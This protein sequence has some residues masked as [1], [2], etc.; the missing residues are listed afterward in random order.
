MQA[1]ATAEKEAANAKKKGA[2]PD[3]SKFENREQMRETMDK[4]KSLPKGLR[5]LLE[6]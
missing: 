6:G 5:E 2:K 3:Y 1:G 4:D